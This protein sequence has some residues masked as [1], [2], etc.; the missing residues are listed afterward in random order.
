MRAGIPGERIA[1][2]ETP[3][4]E[5]RSESAHMIRRTRCRRDGEGVTVSYTLLLEQQQDT[6]IRMALIKK[7]VNT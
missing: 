3:S 1:Q 4:T 6:S 7:R 2:K 5:F